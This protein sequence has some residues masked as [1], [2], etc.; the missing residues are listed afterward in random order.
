MKTLYRKIMAGTIAIIMT[1]TLL[2][3]TAQPAFAFGDM[4]KAGYLTTISISNGNS[5]AVAA[6]GDLYVWGNKHRFLR[7]R[8]IGGDYKVQRQSILQ[9]VKS[10][11]QRHMEYSGISAAA[12]R[13][14]EGS[15]AL[16]DSKRIRKSRNVAQV[17][18]AKFGVYA[19]YMEARRRV[20]SGIRYI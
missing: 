11:Y 17:Q 7:L 5:A 19:P 6:N 10:R 3:L 20:A 1:F 9:G 18:L 13:L 14:I 16:R 15:R 12:P 2:P 4:G 8:Q